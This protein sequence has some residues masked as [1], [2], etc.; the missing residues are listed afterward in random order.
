MSKKS[1]ERTIK[2]NVVDTGK[3]RFYLGL[4]N[5]NGECHIGSHNTANQVYSNSAKS[6]TVC[7]SKANSQ[8]S[9]LAYNYN[10]LWCGFLELY[11][12]GECDAFAMLHSD[13]EVVGHPYWDEGGSWA[14]FMWDK[15][16]EKDLCCLSVVNA[17]KSR[18]GHSSVA[19]GQGPSGQRRLSLAE[20]ENLPPTFDSDEFYEA[21][22]TTLLINT[23]IMLIKPDPVWVH[24]FHFEFLDKLVRNQEGKMVPYMYP[25]DWQMSRY[26]HSHNCKYGATSEVKTLHYGQMAYPN[27]DDGSGLYIKQ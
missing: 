4:P 2:D 16:Q 3:L 18:E 23:G 22:G 8:M 27:W 11:N 26:F 24:E 20:L 14:D 15:M 10:Q 13:L 17:I 6:S 7:V 9:A 1:G 19:M 25:E 12:A 21:T 5:Y